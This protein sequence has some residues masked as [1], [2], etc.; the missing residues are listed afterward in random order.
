M[1]DERWTGTSPISITK[2]VSGRW[3]AT[4]GVPARPRSSINLPR[5]SIRSL[6]QEPA[7]HDEQ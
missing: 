4:K 7:S 3:Y 5:P 1:A 2:T 6:G